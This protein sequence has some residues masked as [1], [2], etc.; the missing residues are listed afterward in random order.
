MIHHSNFGS[1][2][3]HCHFRENPHWRSNMSAELFKDYAAECGLRVVEQR[4]LDWAPWNG[5]IYRDLDCV[6]LFEKI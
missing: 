6:S 4:L 2:Q 5:R 3:R 1:R